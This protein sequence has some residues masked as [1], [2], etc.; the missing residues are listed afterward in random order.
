M[1]PT[2]RRLGLLVAAF[3]LVIFLVQ[4]WQPSRQVR[5]HQR[6]LLRA[7]EKRNWPAVSRFIA[8]EYRD[9][10][11]QDKDIVLN[12]AA[13]AFGQFLFC[14]L[15]GTEHALDVHGDSGTIVVNLTLTGSGGPLADFAK[16]R[17][18]SLSEPFTFRWQRR[19]WK[20]WDWLLVTADQPELEFDRGL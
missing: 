18:S 9:R 16:Q 7:V 19:S 2:T 12:N 20:P 1:D 17:V 10:W 11:G 4:L 8:P 15:Q 14:G 13:Q 6:H 3:T 5:L